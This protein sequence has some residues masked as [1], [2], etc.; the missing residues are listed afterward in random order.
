MTRL[1]FPLATA[2]REGF[3]AG[4]DAAS[5]RL[6]MDYTLDAEL[7]AEHL[8]GRETGRAK[9]AEHAALEG[10]TGHGGV[11]VEGE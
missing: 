7:L 5:A 2:Y 10:P 1:R 11:R 6:S 9:M 4:I 8:R 3:L